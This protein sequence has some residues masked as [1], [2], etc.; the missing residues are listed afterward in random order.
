MR[1]E[2]GLD[3]AD[4]AP[5]PGIG[6]RRREVGA[7]AR[8][9]PR[10]R[11]AA[12][13]MA[14]EERVSEGDGLLGCDRFPLETRAQGSGVGIGLAAAA[15]PGEVDVGQVQERRL[16]PAFGLLFVV[17]P[18]TGL[19]DRCRADPR[20]DHGL[21]AIDESTADDG[22]AALHAE[23]DGAGVQGF[24]ALGRLRIEEAHVLDQ[25]L[26]DDGVD[27]RQADLEG[28]IE[29]ER[30][31]DRLRLERLDLL[32]VRSTADLEGEGLD[33]FGDLAARDLDL[34]ALGGPDESGLQDEEQATEDEEMEK[35]CTQQSGPFRS[36]EAGY[37][38]P[39]DA[40]SSPS[41][42]ARSQALVDRYFELLQK[43]DPGIGELFTPDARWLAPQSAPVGRLHEGRD[44]V[45]RL[46]E[47]G[48]GLY[49]LS[50][51]MEIE[52]SA[53]LAG[54]ALV[55]VEMTIR[56]TTKAGEP[57]ENHYV[58]VFQLEDGRISEVREYVDS[59]YAQCML[60][61]PA[62]QASPFDRRRA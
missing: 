54:E 56:A 10:R 7:E 37:R 41:P 24:V 60:F 40:K 17:G 21:D 53:S 13:R 29:P 19:V 42:I 52:R 18:E 23:L 5:W 4:P 43:G 39:M 32:R 28:L 8:R 49:D 33:P 27:R 58:M 30:I 1:S 47:S 11:R 12:K 16:S 50:R 36:R 31:L 51:P 55:Y 38:N 6:D 15:I 48:L 34:P 25:A 14:A 57:Y 62:G 44:A 22:I 59:L 45:L 35:R 46:M 2:G 61:D 3:G 20:T 26:M 9:D